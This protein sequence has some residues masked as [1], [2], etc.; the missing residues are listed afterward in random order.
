[1]HLAVMYTQGIC[2]Y[3]VSEYR[4]FAHFCIGKKF[5]SDYLIL[6]VFLIKSFL[7]T[8]FADNNKKLI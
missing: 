3:L 8:C 4:S 7:G 2:L 6:Y 5:Y 1:M